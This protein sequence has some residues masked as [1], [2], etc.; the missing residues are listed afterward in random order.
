MDKK[1]KMVKKKQVKKKIEKNSQ[2]WMS[3]FILIIMV[4]SIAGF[5][6][7]TAGPNAGAKNKVTQDR[8]LQFYEKYGVWAAVKN[9]QQFIFKNISSFDGQLDLLGLSNQIKDK[10]QIN[11]YVEPQFDLSSLF[12]IEKALKALNINYA[13]ISNYNCETNN[14]ILTYNK[15]MDNSNCMNFIANENTSY[16]RANALVYHLI[17]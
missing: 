12:I 16:Y 2:F 17:K 14:L 11:I 9:N 10:K 15:S 5:A 8:P 4:L 7:I 3:I 13:E 6:M 1:I